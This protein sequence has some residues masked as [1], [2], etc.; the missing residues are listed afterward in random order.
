MKFI[1]VNKKTNSYGGTD[2]SVTIH[3]ATY[4]IGAIVLVLVVLLL[5]SFTLVN[6]GQRG[7]VVRLGNVQDRVLD[8]GLHLKT[9][10]VDQ[11]TKMD[12][13]T[14]KIETEADSASKDLQSISTTVAL[15][16]A[17]NPLTVN[18]NYQEYRKEVQVRLIDPSIQEAVKA[19]TAQFT[20]EEVITKRQE[21]GTMIEQHLRE[22][23]TQ[24][25]I[26]VKS[27][28]IV[29]FS[30]SQA[31]DNAIEAKQVAEQRALQAER[32]L[33]RIEIEAQQTIERAKAEA[34]AIRIT[35]DALRE[36]PSLVELE[37]VKKWNGVLPTY[38]GDA[39]P[40]ITIK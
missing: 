13:T 39:V 38:T 10:F 32:D 34:E 36:N 23:L 28:A 3:P 15:N 20:A 4:F 9:P 40:F 24:E 18:T 22:K 7:V 29:N 37:A 19:T 26:E 35:G 8:E 1:Q 11:V 30:F 16:Y 27:I 12:V 2:T 21:V 31:F 25:G 14:Q 33:E 17:L 6:A 5:G